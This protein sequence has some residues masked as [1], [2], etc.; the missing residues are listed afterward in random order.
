[1]QLI[2]ADL[3]TH[4]QFHKLFTLLGSVKIERYNFKFEKSKRFVKHRANMDAEFGIN[5]Y[6]H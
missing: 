5:V 4:Q 3:G 2:T 6:T 1:M